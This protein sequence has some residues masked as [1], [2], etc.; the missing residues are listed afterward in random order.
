[1]KVPEAEV[2]VKLDIFEG[3][4][5]LTLRFCV[6]TKIVLICGGR[7]GTSREARVLVDLRNDLGRS[8]E[9]LN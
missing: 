2:L 7:S 1:V 9:L 3:A 6:I 8:D 5:R 4:T